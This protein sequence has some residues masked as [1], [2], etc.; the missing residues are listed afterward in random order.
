[1]SH[2]RGCP[3]GREHYEYKD[4][5]KADCYKQDKPNVIYDYTDKHQGKDHYKCTTCGAED[6][7]DYSDKFLNKECLPTC[8][9]NVK[10]GKKF[11]TLVFIGRFQP[12]HNGHKAVIDQALKQ[13]K[14]VVV[15]I[16]SAYQ[17][18]SIKNPFT[19][20]ERVEM[21]SA[22]YQ[23]PVYGGD[24]HTQINPNLFFVPTR[25]YPY[26][27][28]K[29]MYEVQRGV[30]ELRLKEILE[31]EEGKKYSKLKIG[32]IGHSKDHTSYYLKIFPDW[33]DN[34]EVKNVDGINAT[35][36]RE[37]LFRAGDFRRN[38]VEVKHQK[39]PE[40]TCY[41]LDDIIR[42]CAHKEW[43]DLVCEY[44]EIENYKLKWSVAPYAPTFVATDA[45]LTQSGYILL[46]KR[47]EFPFKDHWA[48]PGGYLEPTLSLEDNVMKEL[49]EET[50]V[51][52]PEKVLRGS[53]KS[54]KVFDKYD[55]DPRGRM[56]S[57]AFHIDLGFPSEGLPKVKADSDAKK[58][59]W[60]KISDLDSEKLAFDHYH[61]INHFLN[62]E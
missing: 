51:K 62:L 42:E 39:I 61:I 1:M 10:M 46:I 19:F 60:V 24:N 50:R 38:F 13:A 12:F 23:I 37:Q 7:C 17:P 53:I 6:W 35:N 14:K 59:E 18:R 57:H 16:G 22:A 11:D 44:K 36:I 49:R 32:L 41:V 33:K 43:N 28:T 9:G 30:E 3:C 31:M 54:A 40:E 29:W 15:V 45:V 55:R 2:D 52:V 47:K 4:C 8:K 48:L 26:D 56:I 21:I 34:V 27:D 25:D 20:E 5:N 58:A